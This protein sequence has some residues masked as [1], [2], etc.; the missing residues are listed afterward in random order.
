M[1]SLRVNA[2]L[3]LFLTAC[4]EPT[5]EEPEANPPTASEYCETTADMFCDYYMRCG[6]M[7]AASVEECR[8]VFL[9]SCNGQYE[10]HYVA[11]EAQGLLTL[12]ESGIESCASHL[13]SVECADQHYDL[14]GD[15]VDMWQGQAQEGEPCG[16]GIESFVCGDG[17]ECTIGLDFCGTCTPDDGEPPTAPTWTVVG[18]GDTCDA[19]LR[20]PYRSECI[21][22][23]CVQTP[24]LGESCDSSLPC[25]TGFCGDGTCVALVE[26]GATC[27]TG[28]ACISGVC[29]ENGACAELPGVCFE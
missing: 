22:Q 13:A 18:V 3:L 17:T 20:C 27:D 16:L 5:V 14:E 9:E 1:S 24:L 15:C 7:A 29:G 23:V 10:P 8:D 12:S 25:A 26:A 21:G 28:A 2:T 4:G 19:S 6:R 11:L